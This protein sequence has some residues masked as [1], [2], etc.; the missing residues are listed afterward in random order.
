MQ[1]LIALGLFSGGLD[2]ILA[3]RTVAEQG[4]QV[5]GLKF[6]TPFFDS[7][8][9]E[10]KEEYQREVRAKYGLKVELVDLS[11]GYLSL[12]H[13]P[14]HGFGKYCNPC[15]D[16][17]ILMLSTARSLMASYGASFLVTGEVVGQ[18]PMSQRRDAMRIIERDSGC[19]GLLLRPLSAQLLPPTFV[20]AEGM[21]DRARLH[22][23]SGRGRRPQMELARRF[24]MTE[25]PNPAGGCLL[26]DPNLGSR[27]KALFQGSLGG[28]GDRLSLED[29]HLIL[30]GR[31]FQIHGKHWLVVGRNQG[32]NQRI[33]ALCREGDWLLATTTHPG[34]TALLRRAAATVAREE[35]ET[36]MC[37]AA[38]IVVRYSKKVDNRPV[39]AEVQIERGAQSECRQFMPSDEDLVRSWQL[40]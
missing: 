34:P 6:V 1:Q 13:N 31:Q 14:T 12:L 17:K 33:R 40:S 15:I 29:V 27:I 4:V 21:V 25:H 20:E 3:C 22:G 11:R 39:P 16:C 32:E 26:T 5:I 35:Q 9:L 7:H 23:F 36:V 28:A 10:C 37:Q 2:S 18:R 19:T 24:G 38:G 8:L 30:T